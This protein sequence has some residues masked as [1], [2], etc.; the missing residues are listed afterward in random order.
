MNYTRNFLKSVKRIPYFEEAME[1]VMS[2]SDGNVWL[3]GGMVYRGIAHELYGTDLPK[4]D[5]D[6]VVEKPKESYVLPNDWTVLQNSYG[7]PKFTNGTYEIDFV[8]LASVFSITRRKITPT[9]ENFL[10]GTPLNIQSIAYCVKKGTVVGDIGI[11]GIRDKVIRV[12]DPEEAIVYAR[13]KGKSL[14]D[15]MLEKANQLGFRVATS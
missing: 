10:T 14:E 11:N 6:F 12:N 4:V 9:F 2:N 5:F 1:I 8:P 3:I 7:N 15:I 13:L